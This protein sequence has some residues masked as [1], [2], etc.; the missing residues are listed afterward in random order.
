MA[1]ATKTVNVVECSVCGEMHLVDSNEF[2]VVYGNIT[3]GMQNE[4]IGSNID[5]KGKV[6]DSR[7]FCRKRKCLEALFKGML[8]E[9]Y[10]PEDEL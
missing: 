4:V 7:V 10:Q 6:S 5:D 8:G 1:A 3:V 9:H 2:V